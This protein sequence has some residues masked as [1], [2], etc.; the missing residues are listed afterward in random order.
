[1]HSIYTVSS[2][3]LYR[4][5][6]YPIHNHWPI[7]VSFQPILQVVS[8]DWIVKPQVI[9]LPGQKI[10]IFGVRCELPDPPTKLGDYDSEGTP[11]GGLWISISNDGE[12]K[13]QRQMR[14]VSYDSVC[15]ACNKSGNCYLKVSKPIY[16]CL[17]KGGLTYL[18]LSK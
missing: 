10:D 6:P 3:I 16:H 13:S 1:M 15:T 11:A 18:P 14:F 4:S 9:K 5:F 17:S 2:N 8:S 7:N 12:H